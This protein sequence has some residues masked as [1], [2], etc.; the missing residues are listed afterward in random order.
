MLCMFGQLRGFQI[1]WTHFI[2]RNRRLLHD[3]LSGHLRVDPADLAKAREELKQ[4]QPRKDGHY[5][6]P[7]RR[8]TGFIQY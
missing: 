6:E 8:A 7:F 2:L 5:V 4:E 1:E 3:D